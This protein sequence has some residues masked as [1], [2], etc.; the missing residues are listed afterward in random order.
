MVV[1]RVIRE[2]F[3]G[4]KAFENLKNIDIIT[5]IYE[6]EDNYK[7]LF[8]NIINEAIKDYIWNHHKRDKSIY[9]IGYIENKYPH[10]LTDNQGE[11]NYHDIS[12]DAR[13]DSYYDEEK[14]ENKGLAYFV[15]N[16][17]HNKDIRDKHYRRFR[18]DIDYCYNKKEWNM[19]QQIHFYTN[20]MNFK[21]EYNR[22]WY[23]KY[24]KEVLVY[25]IMEV[26]YELQKKK[27]VLQ[28]KVWVKMNQL[29]Q[30]LYFLII[31]DYKGFKHPLAHNF[32][33]NY[34]LNDEITLLFYNLL[35]PRTYDNYI[36]YDRPPKRNGYYVECKGKYNQSKNK[37]DRQEVLLFNTEK[38]SKRDNGDD[39]H[40]IGRSYFV[41]REDINENIQNSLNTYQPFTVVYGEFMEHIM[42]GRNSYWYKAIKIHRD[43]NWYERIKDLIDGNVIWENDNMDLCDWYEK[44]IDYEA[45]RFSGL[46]EECGICGHENN[47]YWDKYTDCLCESCSNEFDYIDDIDSYVI[48]KDGLTYAERGNDDRFF[49]YPTTSI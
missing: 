24:A 19:E 15:Y 16:L 25:N 2:R 32:H 17:I 3:V 20:Y 49:K 34:D 46:N 30:E 4:I 31:Y 9:S 5:E 18:Q 36:D 13:Y 35:T 37:C 21:P 6:I 39:Q 14:N 48:F 42:N 23:C 29:P 47:D 33:I 45:D 28:N 44:E 43:R 38:I 7:L 11:K 10:F 41:K 8:D 1:K 26:I 40:D 12:E 27:E 22:K